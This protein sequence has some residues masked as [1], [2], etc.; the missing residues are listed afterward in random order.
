MRKIHEGFSAGTACPCGSG[1]LT[2]HGVEMA[3]L[4]SRY[5]SW[6]D[7]RRGSLASG[8]CLLQKVGHELKR[9]EAASHHRRVVAGMSQ[10][11][12]QVG[13]RRPVI[14]GGP[15]GESPSGSRA[16]GC[17]RD[18]LFAVNADSSHSGGRGLNGWSSKRRP[19]HLAAHRTTIRSNLSLAERG[20]VQPRVIPA[21]A[22]EMPIPD[23]AASASVGSIKSNPK[24]NDASPV[25]T[26]EEIRNASWR[27]P[28]LR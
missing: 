23:G 17:G 11:G 2:V 19:Q 1:A 14:Q 16:A 5:R 27:R 9:P 26:S 20:S 18:Y 13:R 28:P 12:V 25:S 22:P 10:S 24:K 4:L 15:A 21:L 6:F 8:L 7:E 3:L